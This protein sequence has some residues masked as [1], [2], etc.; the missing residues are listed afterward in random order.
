MVSVG[1]LW[2]PFVSKYIFIG[3]S[4][5]EEGR[6]TLPSWSLLSNKRDRK[7]NLI[8]GDKSMNKNKGMEKKGVGWGYFNLGDIGKTLWGSDIWAETGQS[9]LN[10]TQMSLEL[11]QMTTVT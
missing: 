1:H 10:H 3:P 9:S 2:L 6:Q 5:D 8:S 11:K 4:P 7:K